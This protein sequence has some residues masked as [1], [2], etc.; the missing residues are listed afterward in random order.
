[1]IVEVSQISKKKPDSENKKDVNVVPSWLLGAI[2]AGTV[3]AFIIFLALLVYFII[4][5]RKGEKNTMGK[6]RRGLYKEEED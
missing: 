5:A 2:I 3:V 4:K 6:H 1:M